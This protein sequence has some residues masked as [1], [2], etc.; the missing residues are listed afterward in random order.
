MFF[1]FLPKETTFQGKANRAFL[2]ENEDKKIDAVAYDDDQDGKW[3]RVE[4]VS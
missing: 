4:K 3:D 2:D 1:R